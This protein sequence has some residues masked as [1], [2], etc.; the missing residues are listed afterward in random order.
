MRKKKMMLKYKQD[1]R[2]IDD[3]IAPTWRLLLS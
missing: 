3:L 1:R 2:I